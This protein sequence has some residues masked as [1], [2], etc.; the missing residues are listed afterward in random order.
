VQP[1]PSAAAARARLQ[2]TLAALSEAQSSAPSHLIVGAHGRWMQAVA[3]VVLCAAGI[4]LASWNGLG[5]PVRPSDARHV[6]VRPIQEL[7]PGAVRRVPVGELCG[8]KRHR[9]DR[10]AASLHERVFRS[11]GADMRRAADYELDYLITPELGGTADARNLWPQAYS[12]TPWNAFVKDELE[13]S[14][15][16][17]VCEGRIELAAAQ[18][19][20]AEDW[21]AAYKQR[22]NTDGPLR[23]YDANPLSAVDRELLLSEL[24][25]RGVAPSADQA[26]ASG[27]LALFHATRRGWITDGPW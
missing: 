27:L 25:E 18:Q 21:I 9:P 19:Q 1:L 24:E 12:R 20:I 7:T 23:D 13:R 26:D 11:Y 16:R 4:V 15:H 10:I 22:F 2:L 5:A 6:F 3:L 14:L 8:E 17:D